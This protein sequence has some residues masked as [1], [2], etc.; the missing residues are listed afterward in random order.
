MDG[1]LAGYSK[2]FKKL[3][4]IFLNNFKGG[5]G[6]NYELKEFLNEVVAFN[7]EL[8]SQLIDNID[9][10]TIKDPGLLVSNL[11]EFD[12]VVNTEGEIIKHNLLSLSLINNGLEELREKSIFNFAEVQ[13]PENFKSALKLVIKSSTPL[14]FEQ[15]LQFAGSLIN[16]LYHISLI[17]F[18]DFDLKESLCQC[19]FKKINPFEIS[20][21]K[22]DSIITKFTDITDEAIRI[23]DKQGI[24]IHVNKSHENL[25]GFTK[26]E[27]MG[28]NVCDLIYELTPD[29]LKHLKLKVDLKTM[30]NENMKKQSIETF[31][32]KQQRILK[33]KNGHLKYVTSEIF[34]IDSVDDCYFVSSI[35]DISELKTRELELLY[36][37]KKYENLLNHLP[38]IIY[39][40]SNNKGGLFYTERVKIILGYTPEEFVQNRNLWF[41]LVHPEDKV[42]YEGKLSQY[43]Q[44]KPFDCEYRIRNKAGEIIWLRD[45]FFHSEQLGAEIISEGRAVD[46]TNQKLIEI[47]LQE[48]ELR[49]KNMFF[50]HSS[51][52][53][54]IDPDSGQ[55]LNANYAASSFYGYSINELCKMTINEIN[56]SDPTINLAKRQDAKY[57]KNNIFIFEHIIKGG[58]KKIVEVHSSP[59]E[60]LNKKVLFSIIHDITERIKIENSLAITHENYRNFLHSIDVFLFVLDN[61]GVIK[62]VNNSVKKK[63][64]YSENEL[65]GKHILMLHPIDRAQEASDIIG[66]MIAGTLDFCP[67]PLLT[68]EGERIEV[69]TRV[70]AGEWDNEPVLFGVSKDITNLVLSEEKF[71]KTFHLNSALMAISDFES[72]IFIDVNTSF[73]KILGY[74]RKEVIGNTAR[75]L[76]LFVNSKSRDKLIGILNNQSEWLDEIG[77]KVRTKDGE[78]KDGLFSVSKIII[79]GKKYL[80]TTMIDITYQKQANRTI[81]NQN[82]EL[83]KLN[84]EMNRFMTILSHDL[85]SPFNSMLGFLELIL[86]N[87]DNY[88]MEKLK[89]HLINVNSSAILT[90]NLL[91]DLLNWIRINSQKVQLSPTIVN[92]KEFV[93][94]VLDIYTF[95]AL[96]KGIEIHNLVG[97][98]TS[99]YIDTA[100]I[101]KVLRNLI[102]NSIK[103]SNNGS[104]IWISAEECN[105]KI[106]LTVK[107]QGIGI[108]QSQVEKL[109][110]ISFRN[111]TLG[112]MNEKGTGLGLNLCKEMIQKHQG[113]IW[114][115]SEVNHGT[116]VS[117]T[118]P[119]SDLS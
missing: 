98:D 47:Q 117:F 78:K 9:V 34:K 101:N 28:M 4:T 88:G 84:I 57:E 111:S 67:I 60:Y 27:V 73:L 68:K 32:S 53:L 113:E 83:T 109:F 87:F 23:T 29:D 19:K 41:S 13:N 42:M 118:I 45:S 99:V 93:T 39:K 11:L 61:K 71:S 70:Y 48:S 37:N 92:L 105:D 15:Y 31:D 108:N 119:A 100:M 85:R 69:E 79:G 63:L 40:I 107:D 104:K 22:F 86:L 76:N 43:Y 16:N 24:I 49:F 8:T 5:K 46:I 35:K 90:Y 65:L 72:G 3:K 50:K 54:L 95:T 33:S 112:T 91:D 18:F 62:F 7:Q 1:N 10:D 89:R 81:R 12:F 110:N 55:I 6:S 64:K 114:I 56:T 103:F 21:K 94:S 58:Q 51:I 66:R 106:K 30:I 77:I 26:D 52:M 80:L 116:E 82:K 25:T 115:T 38:A 14:E 74:T 17:P 75:N 36:A 2:E 97:N 59:V 96:E 20:N 44:G 102:S